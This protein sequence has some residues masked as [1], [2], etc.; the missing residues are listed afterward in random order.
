LKEHARDRI[1]ISDTPAGMHV[2]VW[3]R[4]YDH[5]RCEALVAYA[6]DRGLGL[7]PISPLYI[8]PPERQGLILGYCALSVAELREAMQLFG[9]CLDHF[10]AA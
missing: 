4:G 10:E 2:V 5:A 6:H 7:Y 1:E 9:Q 8:H 3:L